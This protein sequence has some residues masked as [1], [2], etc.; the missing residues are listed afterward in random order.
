MKI[1][2]LGSNSFMHKMVETTDKLLELG[3]DAF[4][5]PDYRQL[6]KGERVEQ[7]KQWEAGEKA[8]VKIEN[9]Y[10]RQHYAHILE[11]DGIL[12]INERKND[13]DNY[14]GGNVL[15]EMGQAYVHDKKIFLLN[16]IPNNLSYSD[17]IKAL[18]PIC[19]DGKLNIISSGVPPLEKT[20]KS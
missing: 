1:Y 15:I 11:S 20:Q 9:D 2:V 6:V 5:H 4:I 16:N 3:I 10:F 7:I 8:R 13:I 19:L 14:I 12:V 18:Q 17:E